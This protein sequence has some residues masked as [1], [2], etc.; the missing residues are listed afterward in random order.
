[1]RWPRRG[2]RSAASRARRL[3]REAGRL[4][5]RGRAQAHRPSVWR[6]REPS[7]RTSTPR[8]PGARPA[9]PSSGSARDRV[10]LDVGR[11]RRRRRRQRIL[12]TLDAG[13][14]RA[15]AR[16]GDRAPARRLD[17][18][19]LGTPGTC[20]PAHRR[21]RSSSQSATR[22]RSPLRLLPRLVVWHRGEWEQALALTNRAGYC[23]TGSSGPGIKRRTRS[24]PPE[25]QSPP[26]ILS[27]PRWNATGSTVAGDRQRHLAPRPPRCHA[28]RTRTRRA[29][30]DEAVTHLGPTVET[31]R[32]LGF[33][34]KPDLPAASLGRARCHAGNYESGASTL[35]VGIA[36]AEATG[37][38]RLA[39]LGRVHLGR[40][41]R[42][43]ERN[44]E[45]RAALEAAAAS[46]KPPAAGS[47]RCSGTHSSPRSIV[48]AK[49]WRLS[50]S[51]RRAMVTLPPKSSPSTRSPGSRRIDDLYAVADSRMETA[52]HFITERD[53]VDR[54]A[55]GAP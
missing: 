2:S 39:A 53:R 12:T 8:S 13:A 51:E 10:R 7:G 34:R 15:G 38:V 1:M 50:S 25:R 43:L 31:S 33:L 46:I 35:A 32:R 55:D 41:L 18:G 16:A 30:L 21:R 19:V 48:I 42:A 37:D 26:V 28:R 40:I 6:S 9:N 29:T 52:A 49:T 4:V 23:T 17:R 27:T 22:P 36:K 3:V 45:A 54:R 14:E 11:P 47:S 5:D 44:T 24:S 20:S